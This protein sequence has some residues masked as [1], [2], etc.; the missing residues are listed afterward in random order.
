MM[1]RRHEMIS[2][3]VAAGFLSAV[4]LSPARGEGA[5]AVAAQDGGVRK[6]FAYAWS[7][8]AATVEDA[9][10]QALEGCR[11]QAGLN[12]VPA[13]NCKV[14]EVIRKSF[15]IAAAFDPQTRMAAW[16]VGRDEAA[17]RTI[18]INKCGGKRTACHISDLDCDR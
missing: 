3:A 10:K 18:A 9:Q 12:G 14:V 11:D 1:L 4:L 6:G 15:C 17:A 16:G 13:K 5:L 8:R 7:L 2:R